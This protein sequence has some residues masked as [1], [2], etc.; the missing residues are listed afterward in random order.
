MGHGYAHGYRA[1]RIEQLIQEKEKLTL[2]DMRRIQLDS[3]VPEAA[4]L[5]PTMLRVLGASKQALTPE[6]RRAV[7]L[8][9]SW[10]LQAR[11]KAVAP[12]IFRLWAHKLVRRIFAGLD[13]LPRYGA[14][15]RVLEGE[16]RPQGRV[17][18]ESLLHESLTAALDKLRADL[19]PDPK[20]W[21]WERYH[22]IHF[23]SLMEEREDWSPG[24]HGMDG[25]DRTVNVASHGRSEGP[26]VV[27]YAASYRMVVEL[28]PRRLRSE[29]VLAGKQIDKEPGKLGQQQRLWLDGRYRPR[30][31]YPD[32]IEAH[33][34]PSRSTEAVRF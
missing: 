20:R 22:R 18:V 17:P 19:G 7:E 14:L 2:D 1:Q 30:P 3:R 9:E 32:E 25:D 31:F 29:G 16:I 8:L 6:Q 10:D 27:P 33:R 24:P 15:L 4:H 34:R 28:G 11:R 5:L 23:S 26:F 13:P 21:R 12:T